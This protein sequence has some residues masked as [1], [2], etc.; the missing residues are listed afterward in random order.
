M[1]QPQATTGRAVQAGI[2]AWILPGAG[3]YW[4][5]HR[6]LAAVFFVAVSLP[7]WGGIA[8]GGVKTSV[9]PF[10]S[11]WLFLAEMGSG[12][13]TSLCYLLNHYV[14]EVGPREL[15]ALLTGEK[16]VSDYSEDRRGQIEEELTDMVAY[17]PESDVAQIY[18]AVGGLLNL[19]VILDAIARAQTGGLPVF[20]HEVS[21]AASEQSGGAT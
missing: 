18:L 2:L 21:A 16:T 1:K 9:N 6:G 20:H 5:G 15:A 17:Y 8:I 14:G 7:F 4:V 11:K 12:G 10:V 19:L 3:H 13:Y